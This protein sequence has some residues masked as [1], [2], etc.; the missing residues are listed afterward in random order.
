Q[1]RIR[2][3]HS[4]VPRDIVPIGNSLLFG[5]NVEFGLKKSTSIEDVF[6]LHH[7]E[8]TDD[9]FDISP[10]HEEGFLADPKFQSDFNELFTYF[11]G[12][13]LAQVQR[14]ENRMFATLTL[15]QADDKRILRWGIQ[16]DK[17]AYVDNAG[18]LELKP[19]RQ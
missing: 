13:R 3:E 7:F 5:Y 6:S 15:G 14:S 8:R 12:A 9:G 16:G 11:S 19:P 17:V 1:G 2:T 10:L 18:H 4:C